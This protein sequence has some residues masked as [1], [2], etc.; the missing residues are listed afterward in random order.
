MFL[1]RYNLRMILS[2]I[3]VYFSRYGLNMTLSTNKYYVIIF[4]GQ[5]LKTI[6]SILACGIVSQIMHTNN[7]TQREVLNLATYTVFNHT[8]CIN[9]QLSFF[10]VYFTTFY[11][12]LMGGGGYVVKTYP[13]I[14]LHSTPLR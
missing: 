13:S 6:L 1:S 7:F 10:M 3:C 9:V 14:D 2:T 8:C 4:L 5:N 12:S 11:H